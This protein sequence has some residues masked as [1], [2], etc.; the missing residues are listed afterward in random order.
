MCLQIVQ[1]VRK[2]LFCDRRCEAKEN[3]VK[4]LLP[5]PAQLYLEVWG[6]ELSERID[7]PQKYGPELSFRASLWIPREDVYSIRTPH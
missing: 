3:V 2:K 1:Q 4:N 7:R 5:P 6:A